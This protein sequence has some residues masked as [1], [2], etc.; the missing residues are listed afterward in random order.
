MAP[1]GVR[2]DGGN[3]KSSMGTLRKSQK[4]HETSTLPH[5]FDENNDFHL[6][7]T[8]R[9]KSTP[10]NGHGGGQERCFLHENH[11]DRSKPFN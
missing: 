11:P 3:A 9:A 8:F 5:T 6:L 7:A 1:E 2:N 4:C 10:R